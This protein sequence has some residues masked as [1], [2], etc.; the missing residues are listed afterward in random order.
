MLNKKVEIMLN[1]QVE[2]EAFSSA[3]YLAMASWAEVKGMA[4]VARWF[5]IQSDEE[6]IHML[7]FIKYINERGGHAII[8]ALK[9]PDQDF[10]SA[11]NAF[12]DVLKHEQFISDSINNI[13]ALCVTEKDFT[14]Q[15]WLQWFVN[16]Q[17]EEESS[18]TRILDKLN[19]LGEGN[20]Y[21]FDRDIMSLRTE[22]S[23]SE[24]SAEAE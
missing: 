2:K 23:R 24:K 18:V 20:L 19:L 12:K 10:V 11:I 17:I 15:H 13:V 8:P 14:T 6:R 7:K 1:E 21:L 9:Q 22:K 3:L 4:G 5:Y 16:E